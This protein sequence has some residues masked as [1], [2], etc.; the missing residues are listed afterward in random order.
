MIIDTNVSLSRW[1]FRRVP[2]DEPAD[3]VMR[4]RGRGVGLACAG[5]FDGILHKDLAG[6]N[7]RL[8]R[9]CR[10]YGKELLLP[11]GSV[12]PKLPD[13]REDLRR[14][15]EEHRMPG[16]R[17]YPNYHGYDLKDP[18]FGELLT[19][20]SAGGLIVQL[21]MRM[22]DERTQ[23]PLLRVPPVDA[24]PLPDLIRGQPGV[25]I[26]LLHWKG[27]VGPALLERLATAGEVYFEISMLEGLGALARLIQQVSAERVL[28][29][30]NFPLF[31]FES[32]LFKV[33]EAGLTQL[34]QNAIFEGNAQ[35]LL[36]LR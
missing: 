3:L 12:N 30:S 20:A 27:L 36:H 25:R 22:E 15:R 28:F 24:G 5:S 14:C 9:E 17:L 7:T 1:P 26:V 32:A 8:A 16:I 23:H 10:T 4:L 13:W 6:V 21:A 18:A 2:G 33:R 11:F 19:L 34:Q 35:R 31:Y 29:G